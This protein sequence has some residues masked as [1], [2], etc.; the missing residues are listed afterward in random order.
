MIGG[1]EGADILRLGSFGRVM[2]MLLKV[3]LQAFGQDSLGTIHREK[4]PFILCCISIIVAPPVT[5]IVSSEIA[6]D[7]WPVQEPALRLCSP[8]FF[9]GFFSV[10]LL[11]EGAV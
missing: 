7:T 4:V 11:I 2:P 1:E 10:K 8:Y 5:P 6:I 9:F 3:L